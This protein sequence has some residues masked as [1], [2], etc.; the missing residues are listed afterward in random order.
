V[1]LDA[2]PALELLGV[3]KRFGRVAALESVN[4]TV[5]PG[6]VHALL[7]E[8]GAGKTTLMRIAFGLARA[9]AGT[10]S[11]SGAEV[12]FRT[13][14][15]AIDAGIGMVQQH[16]S[17]VPTMTVAENVALGGR[18]IYSDGAAAER[19]RS[20]VEATGLELDPLAMVEDMP[21]AA[22]QRVEI[23][24][25]FSRGASL[26]I[27]DEPTAV[28][29]PTDAE[30]LLER[31]RSFAADGN[32]VVL[33]THKLRE[34]L[35]VADDVTVL[36]RG[37]LAY[38]GS[39]SGATEASLIEAMVGSPQAPAEAAGR[40]SP[41]DI[42]L[43]AVNVTVTDAGGRTQLSDVSIDVR[44]GE[45]V[46]VAGVE[47]NGQ[48]EL[49]RVLAGRILPGRGDV[50]R[51]ATVGFVPE[52]RHRE[53]LILD[54]TLAENYALADAV[55]RTGAIDWDQVGRDTQSLLERFDIRGATPSTRARTLSGGNQQ[56][57]V[58]GRELMAS[59]SALVAENPTRG[60]DVRATADVHVRIGVLRDS[61]GAV[62]FYTSDIDELLA[63]SDRVVV[64]Y[65]G[66]V[67]E[68]GKS[69]QEIARAMVGAVD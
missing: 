21:V 10:I 46:G 17:L 59:P 69:A 48:R 55:N 7:G 35:S 16:F 43:G 52:D 58:M 18:G 1:T 2:A 33:I 15:D 45:V 63:L 36:R 64:C 31:L 32:A 60:L 47:G 65:R 30:E 53:G 41:G 12:H 61:G 25:A 66:T 20:V 57:F 27:L 9:D 6:T 23:V 5:R 11:R 44:Q 68:V 28:L 56:R 24:K 4:L 42:V 3:S 67:T 49:L 39:I 14:A 8:N 38:S 62:V 37:K 13:P 40:S 26:L 34:A 50:R 54:F 51:P 19:V 22:Q 29:A